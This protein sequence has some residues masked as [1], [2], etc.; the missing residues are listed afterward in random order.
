MLGAIA[1]LAERHR[2]VK[3]ALDRPEELERLRG[4][5]ARA[6][7]RELRIPFWRIPWIARDLRQRMAR[8]ITE[9]R[10]SLFPGIAPLLPR[11]AQAGLRLAIV[12]SNAL[13]N[14]QRLLG[15]QAAL[16]STLSCGAA[17]FGKARRFRSVAR[18]L[19]FKGDQVLCVGDE[20]RDIEAA[21]LVGL[22]AGA[23]AWGYAHPVSL[24]ARRPDAW[25]E[26]VEDL[27]RQ[28]LG[29]AKRS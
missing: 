19:G 29:D 27:G 1:G 3:P 28:L 17:L 20:L 12:T 13:P 5:D 11:L 25:F 9:G 21:R 7:M 16:F 14:V 18:A 23:V 26:T 6:V 2:F 10:V 8:E 15:D 4:C 24:R 22:R